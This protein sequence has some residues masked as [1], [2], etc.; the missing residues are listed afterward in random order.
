[1]LS[2]VVIVRF[3]ES[4][5][6]ERRTEARVLFFPLSSNFL[7]GS[8]PLQRSGET[9]ASHMGGINIPGPARGCGRR[10]KNVRKKEKKICGGCGGT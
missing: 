8:F 6:A 1:V 2:S 7:A 4:R 3:E 9:S 5:Q 10:R